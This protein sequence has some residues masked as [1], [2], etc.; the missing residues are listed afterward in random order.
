MAT[1]NTPGFINIDHV[2]KSYMNEINDA[3]T[4]NYNRFKQIVIEGY[5]DL[6]IHHT[7]YIET[8]ISEVN[9]DNQILLPM[10][11]IDWIQ[12]S[13]EVGGEF[14]SLK[15]NPDLIV[16]GLDN[17]GGVVV[18]DEHS[19]VPEIVGQ[20]F[21][22]RSR[23]RLGEFNIDRV[24]KVIG[25][26]GDFEGKNV[27]VEYTST[28]INKSGSTWIPR[29]LLTALKRYLDWIVTENDKTVN[30][31]SK[32][33]KEHLFGLALQQYDNFKNSIGAD[34]LLAIIRSGY[35]QGVKR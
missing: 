9:E 4:A 32:M 21:A 15:E 20:Q 35:T 7:T 2:I 31:Q 25:F 12:V 33:R 5:A 17:C 29:E 30:I 11:Y 10:D 19:N 3:T 34:Q 18:Y 13:L 26:K 28:G 6:N 27:F 16:S 22:R 14:W 24:N 1:T 8:Y 23:N